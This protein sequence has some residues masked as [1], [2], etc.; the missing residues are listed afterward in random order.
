MRRDHCHALSVAAV[1]EGSAL[2]CRSGF[3][4]DE[5]ALGPLKYMGVCLCPPESSGATAAGA[6]G[7]AADAPS[8]GEAPAP[9]PAAA[10]QPVAVPM[11]LKV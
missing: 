4:T 9:V 1:S 5:L 6:S 10:S 11:L 2:F 7:E 3:L 8:T